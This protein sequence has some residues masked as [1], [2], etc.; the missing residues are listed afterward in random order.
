MKQSI[1]IQKGQ[2][3]LIANCMKLQLYSLIFSQAGNSSQL[4]DTDMVNEKANEMKDGLYESINFKKGQ[5]IC[6]Y[7]LGRRQS[8]IF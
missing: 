1:E 8:E 2:K 6:E 7:I 4:S 5:A 3:L